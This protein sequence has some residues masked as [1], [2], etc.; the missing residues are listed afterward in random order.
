MRMALGPAA[1]GLIARDLTVIE[2][3]SAYETILGLPREAIVGRNVLATLADADRSAAERQLRRI[4]DTG[5]PRFFT[6]RHLRPD[7]QALWVNLHVS[8]IGVGDDLRL[9]VT[10]QPLREQTTS[11]SSVEAQW[12]M[13]RLLLSAIRSG[14]QSFGSALIG[15]PATEILLSAYVAEAEAKAI[16]GREIADRI[17][18]DWLLAR[19]WLLALG[20]AGF[21]ELERPGPIMEDTPIRLSP[22]ALT[23]LEAIFGSLVAVAQGAP[24]D[25]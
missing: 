8:R 7:A 12:R 11:P 25:A 6:Q 4:L 24:V 3:D 5:E 15:N 22:Q 18:V 19:R 10:C 16:Q 13:A 23:M 9:A 14:K 21:V 2:I 17:A 1:H 20:N